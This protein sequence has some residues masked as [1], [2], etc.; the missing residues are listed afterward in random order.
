MLSVRN[1]TI[2]LSVIMLSAVML[3]VKAPFALIEIRCSENDHFLS[4]DLT[5]LQGAWS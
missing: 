2:M 1:R 5:R 4:H 3:I